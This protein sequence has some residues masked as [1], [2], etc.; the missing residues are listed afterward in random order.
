[1]T[2]TDR[3]A[4]GFGHPLAAVL[5]PVVCLVAVLTHV[6]TNVQTYILSVLSITT[7]QMVL[8]T[9]S[10]RDKALHAKIDEIILATEGARNDLIHLED[11]NQTQIENL[12]Q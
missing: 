10:K 2:F 12:R 11:Q 1:M 4:N 5:F 6:N 7:T 9:S 3:I 8:I